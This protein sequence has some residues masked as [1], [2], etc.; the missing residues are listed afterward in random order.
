MVKLRKFGFGDLV[1]SDGTGNLG[2]VM[3]G[4]KLIEFGQ[5]VIGVHMLTGALKGKT[6]IVHTDAYSH[7]F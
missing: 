6:L 2:I 5:T 4:P 7:R 3:D 1:T